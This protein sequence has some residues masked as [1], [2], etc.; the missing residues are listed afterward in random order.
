MTRRGALLLLI[1]LAGGGCDSILG[2]SSSSYMDSLDG[3]WTLTITNERIGP[4]GAITPIIGSSTSPYQIAR[5]V[6]CNRFVLESQGELSRATLIHDAQNP[7]TIRECGQIGTDVSGERIILIGTGEDVAGMIRES[8]SR[9]HVWH[10]HVAESSGAV[11]RSV[12]T[13]TR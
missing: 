12:W 6:Q 10:F 3:D 13:L 8:S 1:T 11:R 2:S 5:Q 9:R 4:N 7:N